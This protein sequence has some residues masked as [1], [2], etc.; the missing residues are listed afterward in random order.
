MILQDA[1]DRVL[2]FLEQTDQEE[3]TSPIALEH[4][5][6]AI[7]ELSDKAELSEYDIISNATLYPEDSDNMPAVPGRTPLSTATGSLDSQIAYIK[8]AWLSI[9]SEQS[10]DFE[11]TD[12]D[13][14]LSVYGDSI[15]TPEKWATDGTY[16]YWRPFEA[17][18]GG[19]QTGDVKTIRLLWH[20]LPAQYGVSEEPAI[21]AKAP[22]ACIYRACAIA[23]LW[24]L[25]DSMAQK[26]YALSDASFSDFCVRSGMSRSRRSSM[27][28]FNG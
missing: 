19:E 17:Y 20:S 14:L 23:S 18:P 10:T 21:M 25:D 1:V 9:G 27:E 4:L 28:E 8:T 15:G 22:Y 11:Q 26:Y 6:Q 16:L 12:L 2:L 5:N 13:D 24:L 7:F 3:Y